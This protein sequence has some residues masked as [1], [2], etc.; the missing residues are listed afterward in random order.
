VRHHRIRETVFAKALA[1]KGLTRLSVDEEVFRRH[2]RYGIDYPHDTYFDKE[3]PV[4][5]DI[6]NQ[7]GVH[8]DVEHRLCRSARTVEYPGA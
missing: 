1:D 3:R 8:A 2:G 4:L 6:R 7:L 5:D